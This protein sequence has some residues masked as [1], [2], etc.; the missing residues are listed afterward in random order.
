MP[1]PPISDE[2]CREAVETFQREGT[3]QKAA[4]ALGISQSTFHNRLKH[5][6]ARGIAPGHFE[7]GVAPGYR[8][9]KVT[10]QRNASG[11]V[12]RTWER[13]SP[14][15]DA[16]RAVL[17]AMFE[18]VRAEIAPVAATALPGFTRANLLTLYTLTDFHLAMLAWHRE[19]GADWDI[20]IAETT[21]IAAMQAMVDGAP[22]SEWAIVNIQ[23]DFTHTDGYKPITPGHGHLLD[24]DSRFGKI[25]DVS[26]RMIR[27]LV[28]LALQKHGR[29]KLLICEGNHDQ[30]TSLW[31]R[32][33]F[34]VLY[35]QEPRV[36]VEDSELPYYVHQHGQTM[37]AFH[38]GHLK[39]N[40]QLPLL[41]A[42]QFPIVWGATTKRYA[43]CGHRHHCEEKEHS[44]MTVVQHPTLAARDAYAARGGW[45]SERAAQAITYHLKYGKVGSNMVTPEMLEAA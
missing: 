20:K 24:A 22:D 38:H 1:T 33:L 27:Q 9:G 42:A 17:D 4:M 3:Q 28:A 45:I 40:D 15:A 26:I 34:G 30:L 36:M 5:A 8:M 13:Q 35:E 37:L 19:G 6:A 31:L 23:G 39:K 21:G 7:S 25:A 2:I 41:F 29:I 18:A 10:V 11:G 44:G 16:Q 43:H 12:E 14:D 32:K